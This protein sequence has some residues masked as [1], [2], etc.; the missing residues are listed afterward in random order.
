MYDVK[1]LLTRLQHFWWTPKPPEEY[2]LPAQDGRKLGVGLLAPQNYAAFNLAYMALNVPLDTETQQRTLVSIW[3][4]AVTL[5]QVSAGE[6]TVGEL[7]TLYRPQAF[8]LWHS[9]AGPVGDERQ[10]EFLKLVCKNIMARQSA[11]A[12]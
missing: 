10:Q 8:E 11:N 9:E 1:L 12:T 7:A 2:L 6:A 4:F 3:P 5:S